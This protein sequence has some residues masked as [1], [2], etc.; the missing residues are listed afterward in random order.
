M[1]KKL[2]LAPAF[3]FAISLGSLLEF[4]SVAYAD[5]V[6][7]TG[8]GV[9]NGQ[10]ES[11][12]CDS[13]NTPYLLWIFTG[14]GA[15]GATSATITITS[16]GVVVEGPTAMTQQGQGAFHYTSGFYDLST[17]GASVIHNNNPA[18]HQLVISHGCPGEEGE[19][20]NGEVENGEEG[21]TLGEQVEAPTGAV[22]AGVG[23]TASSTALLAIGLGSSL[24]TLGYGVYRLR[25]S[26]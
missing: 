9:S 13:Q 15:N 10:L 6:S 18:N 22:K 11:V 16:N 26:E 19:N 23:G 14:G 8:Q 24:A 5:P 12:E 20:G 25:K 3:V 2:I 4:G 17:I 21:V 7:W 1:I